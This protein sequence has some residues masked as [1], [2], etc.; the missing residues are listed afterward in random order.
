MRT[1][2]LQEHYY[3]YYYYYYCYSSSHFKNTHGSR[4]TVYNG[5]VILSTALCT[6]RSTKAALAI[7]RELTLRF[8]KITQKSNFVYD[9]SYFQ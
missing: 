9:F 1:C 5:I 6:V 8:V 3:Y 7:L 4:Y 2:L